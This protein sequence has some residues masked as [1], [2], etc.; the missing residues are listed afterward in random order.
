[1]KKTVSSSARSVREKELEEENECLRRR[2]QR[3]EEAL[4]IRSHVPH[5][6]WTYRPPRRPYQ[7][8]FRGV[9]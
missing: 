5:R 2:C 7:G 6:D 4:A 9:I 1:M 8:P 3:L